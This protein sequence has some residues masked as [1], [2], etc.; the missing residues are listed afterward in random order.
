MED[1]LK[2]KKNVLFEMMTI[3]V[4]LMGNSVASMGFICR[5]ILSE[6]I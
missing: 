5:K 4:D 3:I 2:V 6:L 1:N